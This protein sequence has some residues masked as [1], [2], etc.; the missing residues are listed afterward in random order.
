MQIKW[1]E[2]MD[3]YKLFSQKEEELNKIKELGDTEKYRKLLHE[4]AELSTEFISTTFGR[5]V[6]RIC[7]TDVL[8]YAKYRKSLVYSE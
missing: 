7:L 6:N 4:L 8:N 5:N 3:F 2:I 1:R